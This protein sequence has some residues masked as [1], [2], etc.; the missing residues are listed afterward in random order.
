MSANNH[1][2]SNLMDIDDDEYENTDNNANNPAQPSAP[3]HNTSQV[4]QTVSIASTYQ[5]RI[6][7]GSR[8]LIQKQPVNRRLVFSNKRTSKDDGG[9]ADSKRKKE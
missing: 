1:I 2:Q 6:N 5:T 8:T 4:Q 9:A 3:P 7:H